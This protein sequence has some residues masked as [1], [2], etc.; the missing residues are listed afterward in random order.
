LTHADPSQIGDAL[1]NLALNARDAMPG[2]GRLVIETANAHLDAQSVIEHSET[3]AGDFVMLAVSDTGT[4]MPPDVI[5]RAMEPFFTTK[6]PAVGSGLGLSMIYGFARQSGGLLRIDSEINVGTTVKLFLPRAPDTA[7]AVI[8]TPE[9]ASAEQGR[10]ETVLLVDDN[11]TLRDVAQRHLIRLGYRVSVAANGPAALAILHAGATFD[12]LFTDVVM[13]E[14]LSGY[15]LAD[16]A[17]DLQPGLKVLFTSGYAS[18]LP[19]DGEATRDRQP[20]L[21]KPYR[22]RELATALRAALDGPTKG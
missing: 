16:A 12:L 1:L 6:P 7:V 18:G 3:G 15:D 20:L 17:R 5:E 2:G 8:D 11:L 9:P 22:Q 13:P 10:N 19:A 14:G 21:R 4:G